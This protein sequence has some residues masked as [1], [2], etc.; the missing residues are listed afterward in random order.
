MPPS[1]NGVSVTGGNPSV[2]DAN[3]GVGDDVT[4]IVFFVPLFA[5]GSWILV[6]AEE[7]C[8]VRVRGFG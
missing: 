6:G 3:P 5:N 2:N 4:G 1:A 8:I 7:D